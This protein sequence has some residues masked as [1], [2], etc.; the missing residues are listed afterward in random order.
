MRA[1]LACLLAI[2][3]VG[4]SSDTPTGT[5]TTTTLTSAQL[6]MHFDS[7]AGQL[8]TSSPGDIRIQWYQEIVRVVGRGPSPS[9]INIR[10]D[11]GPAYL[12][13]VTEVDEFPTKISATLTADS[14][15]ILAAWGPPLRPTQFVDARIRFLPDAGHAD[16]ANTLV[17]FYSDTLGHTITDT[18]ATFGVSVVGNHGDCTFTQLT[19][20]SVE[21][22]P[23]LRAS[24]EWQIVGG[25]GLLY[26]NP[27]IQVSGVELTQ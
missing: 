23:C 22:N 15:Y 17:T 10:L 11:D 2:I 4:C 9:G 3:V 5:G 19:Y 13:S 21:T 24:V 8:Q 25:N 20:L 27:Q 6:A 1:P 12:Q 26:I 18:A 7:L 16:T 14:T